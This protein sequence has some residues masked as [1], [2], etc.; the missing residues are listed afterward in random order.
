MLKILPEEGVVKEEEEEEIS[1]ERGGKQT[2]TKKSD[3]R[4]IRCN[5]DWHDASTCNLP[6]DK[7]EQ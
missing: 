1:K 4:C 6:W 7:I 3:L 5:K 2:Q